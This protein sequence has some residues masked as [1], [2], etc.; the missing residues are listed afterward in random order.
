MLKRIF[1]PRRDEVRDEWRKLQ[2]EELYDL[3]CSPNNIGVT[4]SRKS[5]L[6]G[7]IPRMVERIGVYI[8]F[9]WRNLRERNHVE[10]L[11]VDGRIIIN[12]ILQK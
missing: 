3:Y 2:N 5:R 8:E 9:W 12:V 6:A 10:D 4:K 1:E 11:G 7:H